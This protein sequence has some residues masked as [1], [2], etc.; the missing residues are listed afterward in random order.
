MTDACGQ[1]VRKQALS[2]SSLTL[3]FNLLL[4]LSPF[5][6]EVSLDYSFSPTP[7]SWAFEDG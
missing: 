1:D 5:L 3:V 6:G 4:C 7:L 2:D